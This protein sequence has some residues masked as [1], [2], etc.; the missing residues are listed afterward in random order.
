[1]LAKETVQNIV[2]TKGTKFA[3]VTFIK[4]DGTIRTVNGLFRPTSQMV[5]NERG[6]QVAESLRKNGLI[7]IF[8][9]AER[10]WKSFNINS[11]VEI[12]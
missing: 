2:A 10:K 5:G 1:M 12:V 3:T 6:A 7:P 4:K 8:S 11:V 9:V